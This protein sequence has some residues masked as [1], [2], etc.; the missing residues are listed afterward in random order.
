MRRCGRSRAD[1]G[2]AW[3]SIVS[4]GVA[5]VVGSLL[6]PGLQAQTRDDCLMCHSDRELTG[7]RGGQEVS[8]FV[9]DGLL[10]KSVHGELQC[11]ACHSDLEGSDFPHSE[12]VRP[13]RCVACHEDVADEFARG[14]HGKWVTK[15][16]R[17][18]ESC[19]RCHG[20]HE[21]R[22]S[23]D[24]ASATNTANVEKLCGQCHQREVKE[25]ERSAH[26]SRGRTV[27]RASCV[28]CH[29][30]HDVTKPKDEKTEL[31]ICVTCHPKE[32]SEQKQ[33]VHAKAA[34]RGD[35]LAPSCV[36]C[37][38]HHEILTKSDPT[39]PISTMNVPL[40]CGRCHH[41]GSKVSLFRDIPQDRI[42]ENYSLSIHGEG[43][44]KKG[45]TV[46]AVCTSCHNSHLILKHDSPR[47]SINPKNVATTC[48]RCHGQIEKVHVK[49]IE[50]QLWEE[51]PHKIPACID[52]HQPHKIRRTPVN[53][54]RVANKECM[55]C[56]GNRNLSVL[57]DGKE[58]SLF[59]DEEK[60]NASEHANTACAQCHTEVSSALK[61]PCA[62]INN[63]VDCGVCHANVVE[64]YRD[65]SH[66]RLAAKGDPAA[67]TCE[68][69][70]DP[71]ATLNHRLPIA[72]TFARNVPQLC[73]RCHAAG[74][75]AARRIQADVPDIVESYANSV[76]GKGV[77]EAGL[78]VSATCAD[79]HT[80]HHELPKDNPDSSINPQHLADTC[81]TC[82]RGIEEEFKGSIHWPGNGAERPERLPVCEDCHTSHTISRIDVKGFRT[83]MMDQC[84]R[85]HE[86]ESES[87][88]ETVHGKVSR[89]GEEAAAKCYDC[90]GTHN[91]LPP[92]DPRSTL[93]YDNVVATC[94]TCHPGAHRQFAGYL[95]HATH[96]DSKKYPYLYFTFVF[97]TTL[98]VG[99][100]AFFLLH[101]AFW[102]F[103]LWR[104]KD[105]WK[106]HRTL[107]KER[108]YVRFQ[109]TQR[110]MHVVMIL[111]FF[112]LAITGMTLKFSYAGWAV[113]LSKLLGGFHVTGTLHRIA[114]V[115]LLL[116]FGFHVV[117]IFKAKS[118]SGKRW[119]RFIFDDQSLMF[120]LN[121]IKQFWQNLK[122]FLG[123]GEKPRFGRWTYWEKFDYF[124]VFWGVFVIGSTG[125][126]L[127]FPTFFTRLLPGWMINVATIIHSDEAL[128]AV[129]FIFTIHFFN[130]HFRPDKF[131]MD[132]V[133]F[134]GRVPLEELE[135]DKPGEYEDLIGSPDQE[136]KIAGPMSR[137][138]LVWI[139]AFGYIALTIGLTL[140]GLIIYAMLFSYR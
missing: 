15:P 137:R 30:G 119:L 108:F 10:S 47:S 6:A 77:L 42:L 60:Y 98:L 48:T 136:K 80:S 61:R 54:Q 25:V 33:S 104:T 126:M 32:V 41:E 71:H 101:T 69:C 79:C 19:I 110:L 83:M 112:T 38:S 120:N 28:D 45:L 95:T 123:R 106:H 36:T 12:D 96:H 122:W 105:T 81:G 2:R 107:K 93:S 73:G 139:K 87:Y 9:D 68:T 34:L 72:P 84:G 62:A 26:G 5:L 78:I 129:A 82:H 99:T 125:L 140:I 50:G 131:P 103:R 22:P 124:A 17:T 134:T 24:P 63:P 76:H 16:G 58:V 115:V 128:L 56:H 74:G 133:I 4:L 52:C 51:A 94:A 1:R 37:H 20:T 65:S 7:T 35:P 85:C 132:P 88:F 67:P 138:R 100:L 49:V 57:R 117:Q 97:M 18:S 8:V 39:S 116:L 11:I 111:S 46:T 53:L 102:L 86:P 29:S 127:W 70:H 14:P 27:P 121:D 21:V 118:K 90:H 43:L 59:V 130:T 55:R 3:R 113:F 114:A 89:L 135:H 64:Q 109:A 31:A 75:V 13:V 44:F 40:L 92:D 23:A 66:G 91:I